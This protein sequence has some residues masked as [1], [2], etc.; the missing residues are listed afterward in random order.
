MSHVVR[1]R[2]P[3]AVSLLLALA[4]GIGCTTAQQGGQMR[5]DIARLRAD[6]D[7]MDQRYAQSTEQMERLRKVLDE[8]TALLTRN[9]ADLG[10]QVAKSQTDV[11]ALTGRLEEAKHILE[12]LQQKQSAD[13]ARLEERVVLIEASQGRIAEKVAPTLPDDKEKLWTE[14]QL[15]VTQ[16]LREEAR[17]FLRAYVQRFPQD[18]RAPGA[19]L[20]VGATY[21][22]ELKHTQAAAEYQKL[23]D[24]YPKAPEV[25]EAMFQLG[26]SFVELKFC[27]DAKAIFE[28]LARRYPRS[29]RVPAAKNRVRDLAKM[30]KDRSVCTS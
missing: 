9:S 23:I 30:A 26:S 22:Q 16:G 25:A 10:A 6:L 20:T 13:T 19:M 18:P 12:M 14:A 11:A 17:R 3:L 5:A 7:A 29:P 1:A 28:D 27:G 21:A 8:A 4:L 15:R 24:Q 2:L